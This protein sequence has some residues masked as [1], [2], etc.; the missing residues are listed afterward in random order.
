MEWLGDNPWLGWLGIGLALAAIEAATVDFVFVMLAGGALAASLAAALGAS[1]P[2]LVIISV[3]VGGLLV[4]VVR[5][6]VRSRFLDT[7]TD[8]GIGTAGLVGRSAR[9]VQAVTETDGRVKLGGDTWSAR[10][11]QGGRVCEPGEEVRVISISGATAIVSGES[12]QLTT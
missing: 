12:A 6:I 2:A 1:L 10:I 9:V 4:F 7:V 3:L 11:P 5:P 8:H